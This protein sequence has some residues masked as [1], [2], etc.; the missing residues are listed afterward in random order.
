MA[1][2]T[3]GR[4]PIT[5]WGRALVLLVFVAAACSPGAVD[6]PQPSS[7]SVSSTNLGETTD[8]EI[9]RNQS[10]EAAS[11][12]VAEPRSAQFW[13][14]W[15]TCGEN[16]R[17]SEVA[18]SGGRAAGFVLVDDLLE[19]PGL[20][21]GD[22]VIATCDQAV[23]LLHTA[24]DGEDTD[25]VTVLASMVLL[26]ELNLSAGSISC[27]EAEA[28]ITAGHILLASL[29]YDPATWNPS[30]LEDP[31]EES[32]LRITKM[33]KEYNAGDLCG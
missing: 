31:E 1:D 8:S 24:A 33:L 7:E 13:I 4:A 17:A 10:D 3:S 19:D 2:L 32:A 23:N 25:P 21:T 18:A 12:V 6:G 15:S 9:S 27:I 30:E 22:F 14:L 16:N 28:A 5:R 20:A 26:T 29:D 11:T